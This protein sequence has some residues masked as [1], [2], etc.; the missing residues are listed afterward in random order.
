MYIANVVL[1]MFK[2]GGWVMY[3][4]AA[5]LFL[6]L[7]VLIERTIWWISF[8]K[9]VRPAAQTKAR[10][11]LGTGDFS[12]AWHLSNQSP[13]PFVKNLGD[14]I[15]HAH[16]SL[17]AAMQLDAT[18]WIEKSEARM[19]VLG[20]II[21]LSPLL[22]LFGTV[23]GLMGSFASLGDAQLG[24]AKVTGGIAEALIATAW[25]ICIAISCLLPY[26]YFRKRVSSLRGEF[27]RWINHA[28]ILAASAKAHGHDI[29]DFSRKLHISR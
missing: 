10:E 4:I 12:S 29:E 24:V 27:E 1:E 5:T 16:T 26:N 20:T 6:A 9:N 18:H 8:K 23:V 13:D 17:L 2:E 22:G 11:A 3:P 25:G 15:S 14:G 7:A 28:E 19:W 21:T